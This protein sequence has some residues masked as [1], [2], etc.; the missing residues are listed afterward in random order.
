MKS[1]SAIQ[2]SDPP[3][4]GEIL[5]TD[6]SQ[7]D[8]EFYYQGE[9]MGYVSQQVG[10]PYVRKFGLQVIARG[11]ENF[12]AVLYRDGLPGD[13]WDK[14]LRL[15]S[16]GSNKAGIVTFHLNNYRI[17]VAGNRAI[18]SDAAGHELGSLAKYS[19]LS[20]TMGRQAPYHAAVL[21]DGRKNN[22]W[23]DMKVTQDHLL[24]EGCETIGQY[25]DFHLHLEFRLPYKPAADG[26]ARANSGVYLQ[27]RYEVQVLDSF[28]T[29]GLAN[30]CGGIYR[31]HAP[32]QNMCLPPLRWQTYDIDFRMARFDDQG[33]KTENMRIRVVHNGIVIHNREVES[34]TG[35]GKPEEP[36]GMPILLQDHGN[37]IRYRNIWLVKGDPFAGQCSSCEDPYSE[38]VICPPSHHHG[39][40]Y[41]NTPAPI[42][43]PQMPQR[44]W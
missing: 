34:K 13:G 17:S 41:G 18:F 43:N 32:E 28:G 25:Q 27:R 7:V 8:Q 15:R 37:P 16:I 30:E 35:A 12:E 14:Q 9:Y 19:R 20:P 1:S 11:N 4:P 26:Q 38:N 24:E 44:M 6:L 2:A 22:L 5:A 36:K 23:K 33:K 29:E 42:F 39:F 21:F 3:K 40:S 31:L 10:S